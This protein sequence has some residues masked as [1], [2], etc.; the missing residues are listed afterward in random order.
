MTDGFK[1]EGQGW[2]PQKALQYKPELEEFCRIVKREGVWNYLEIGSKWG[3]SFWHVG[4]VLPPGGK[5]VAVDLP[6]FPEVKQS[7]KRCAAELRKRGLEVH[8]LFGDSTDPAIVEK[9]YSLGPFDLCLIDANHTVQYVRA[10]WKNYGSIARV[11][12][13]HDIAYGHGNRPQRYP[14]EVPQVWNEIKQGFAHTEIKL[15]P[16]GRDN[17]FGILW[18]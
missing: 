5:M 2:A 13:F 9:V 6:Q 10:D 16:T 17:G 8:T 3:G 12:A 1:I 4:Q 14:I 15:D 11:V 18:H 7:L